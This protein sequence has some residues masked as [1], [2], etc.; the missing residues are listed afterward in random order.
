MHFG[1]S[2]HKQKKPYQRGLQKLYSGLNLPMWGPRT[3]IIRFLH[4]CFGA[5]FQLPDIFT[6]GYL[7]NDRRVAGCVVLYTCVDFRGKH[8]ERR[9]TRDAK[10]PGKQ[11]AIPI[12]TGQSSQKAGNRPHLSPLGPIAKAKHRFGLE[13]EEIALCRH[14]RQAD[15]L[16]VTPLLRYLD[17]LLCEKSRNSAMGLPSSNNSSNRSRKTK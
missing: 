4:N 12:S 13:S 16:R 17:S 10:L 6:L 7:L 14:R 2:R 15:L 3:F 9:D 11:I 8:G 5:P 1:D